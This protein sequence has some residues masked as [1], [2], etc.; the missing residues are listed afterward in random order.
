[1]SYPVICLAR[2]A[3]VG[4]A[5][6]VEG[7]LDSACGFGDGMRLCTHVLKGEKSC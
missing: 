1:M 5:W 4:V 3:G 2:D 7:Q 6:E